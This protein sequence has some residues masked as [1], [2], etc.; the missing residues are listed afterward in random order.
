MYIY[1][2]EEREWREWVDTHLVRTFSPNIY[3]TL[4]EAFR[5]FDYIS[6]VGNFNVVEKFLSRYV[7]ALVMYGIGKRLK[8]KLVLLAVE[9]SP[10]LCDL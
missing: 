6:S 10:F 2:R 4:N 3:R 1:D 7:G 5:S 8:K 9:Q